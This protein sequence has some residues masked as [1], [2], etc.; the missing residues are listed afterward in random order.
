VQNDLLKG[1]QEF[2]DTYVVSDSPEVSNVS[3]A[4]ILAGVVGFCG[5]AIAP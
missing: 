3:P 4:G 2:I 5:R 1:S